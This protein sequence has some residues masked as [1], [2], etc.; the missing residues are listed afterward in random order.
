MLGVFRSLSTGWW[1]ALHGSTIAAKTQGGAEE[2]TNIDSHTPSVS[3]GHQQ[4]REHLSYN[5][6][7]QNCSYNHATNL[8]TPLPHLARSV[9]T[10]LHVSL[11]DC[12]SW[13]PCF[14][15]HSYH[16][17]ICRVKRNTTAVWPKVWSTDR[18]YTQA[19]N[20][21]VETVK[22]AI[23]E[24]LTIVK[25]HT[26]VHTQIDVHV[27]L[28]KPPHAPRYAHTNPHAHASTSVDGYT[29]TYVDGN[30][31]RLRIPI[32]APYEHPQAD[33]YQH[34]LRMPGGGLICTGTGIDVD[35]MVSR[36][37]HEAI[38]LRIC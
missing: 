11:Q 32:G 7:D 5:I 37:L 22:K 4:A 25:S 13:I 24:S 29:R 6:K 9:F 33:E 27:P 16:P 14:H 31:Y 21:H 18:E 34:L 35:M 28:A 30:T 15:L 1:S 20:T 2:E 8:N 23:P 19:L 17:E 10:F 38:A 36:Q 26:L 12:L 3:S